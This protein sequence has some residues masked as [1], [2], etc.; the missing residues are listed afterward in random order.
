MDTTFRAPTEAPQTEATKVVTDPNRTVTTDV[1]VPFTMYKSKNKLPFT[2]DYIGAKLT[3]D[4]AAM[5]DD[6]SSVESYLTEL[7]VEG[8]LEDTSKAA[9]EKLKALEKMAGIDKIESRAQ[10]LIKLSEFVKYLKSIERRKH[11]IF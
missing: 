7:V 6:V 9:T 10:R 4:E 8:E 11:D 1:E 2:A 3:W 5:V